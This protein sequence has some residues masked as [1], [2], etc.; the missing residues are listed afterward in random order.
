MQD[1]TFNHGDNKSNNRGDRLLTALSQ[2]DD[3]FIDALAQDLVTPQAL[4]D[5]EHAKAGEAIKA[6]F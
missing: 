5:G 6:N 4:Q 2:F 3:D 1:L